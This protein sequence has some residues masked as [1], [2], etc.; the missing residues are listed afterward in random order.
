[1]RRIF[2]YESP[3]V[4]ALTKIGD[5]IC[6]SVLWFVFSI[7]IVT[8]GAATTAMY[9]AAYRCIRK[10]E[11]GLWK[12]F[13]SSFRE[14]FKRTT[15]TWLVAFV[16]MALF[17][18]DVFVMRNIKLS[19]GAWGNLYWVA[20]A[21]WCAGLGWVVH[22]AGYAAR[23]TGGVRDTLRFGYLLMLL[24]PIRAVC[25]LLIL[26]G[27]LALVL[28]VPFM[29]LATPAL[30]ML[31]GSFPMEKTFLAHMRPEDRESLDSETE[32]GSDDQ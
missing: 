25:V 12:T 17:T 30:V 23:F 9:A 18:V 8:M 21:L 31:L 32:S 11:G 7:P 10:N 3:I 22:M 15:L 1:M 24:H 27:S 5:C 19:G 4:G 14:D 2:G 26:L 20:L 13:W 16:V 6:L 29:L 28:M